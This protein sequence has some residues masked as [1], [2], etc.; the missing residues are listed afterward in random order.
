M[1]KRLSKLYATLLWATLL[2]LIAIPVFFIYLLF[3]DTG[4]HGIPAKTACGNRQTQECQ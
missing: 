2:L 3:F 4:E 1:K